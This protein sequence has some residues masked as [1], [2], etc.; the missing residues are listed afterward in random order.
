LVVFFRTRSFVASSA[1]ALVS[2]RVIVGTPFSSQH[3]QSQKLQKKSK[4]LILNRFTDFPEMFRDSPS[5]NQA[6][7]DDGS[8]RGD[9]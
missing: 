5:V 2:E 4:Q 6:E 7:F 3:A 1:A 9:S 8:P